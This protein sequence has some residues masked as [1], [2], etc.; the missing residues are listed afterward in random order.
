[1]QM[2]AHLHTRPEDPTNYISPNSPFPQL[3]EATILTEIST[4]L[5]Q[6]P[7]LTDVA[8]LYC[9][10]TTFFSAESVRMTLIIGALKN[11]WLIRWLWIAFVCKNK[12]GK[13]G[14]VHTL[15]PAEPVWF[16]PVQIRVSSGILSMD[17]MLRTA[18]LAGDVS[19]SCAPQ[20]RS[21]PPRLLSQS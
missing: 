10:T 20:M 8:W 13:C 2:N 9:V 21:F 4:G 6:I 18:E 1:M 5:N 7:L 17:L 15:A 19:D 16:G 3:W 12:P 11:T 14:N